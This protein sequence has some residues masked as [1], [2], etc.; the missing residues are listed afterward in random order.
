MLEQVAPFEGAHAG[1][2]AAGL[3]GLP[4]LPDCAGAAG[5]CR[6][7]WEGTP[8]GLAG[9][10]SS[11]LSA[12]SSYPA[13]SLLMAACVGV[14]VAPGGALCAAG[15]APGSADSPAGRAGRA[16]SEPCFL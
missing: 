15:A 7:A 10:A 8:A 16:G 1:A 14:S 5:W 9:L 3:P 11:P 4:V 6:L 13:A 12:I 2:D